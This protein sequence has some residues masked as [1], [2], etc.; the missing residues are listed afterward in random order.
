MIFYNSTIDEIHESGADIAV[1]PI[2]STE[3]HSH[4]LPVSTDI[5]IASAVSMKIADKLG[6]Y[7]LP[8]IPISTCKEHRGKKGSVWINPDTF[9]SMIMDIVMSLKY[10][11]FKKVAVILGH[12]GIF[13]AGPVIREINA[14]NDDIK[15]VKVDLAQFLDS[16]EMNSILECRNNLHACEYETS[17][18]MYI[19]EGLVRKDRIVDYIPEVPRDYLNYASILKFS[20]DGVWGMPSLAT[21]EKGE[22]I[23]NLLVEKSVEYI[24]SANKIF[25]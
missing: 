24:N 5:V 15:A 13:I 11:G 12:G 18:M 22:K 4:Y 7:L 8:T 3:Q 16:A 20:K 25:E 9:Y 21:R 10:Q 1:L 19:D 2:G 23:F 14:V 17:L 6:A